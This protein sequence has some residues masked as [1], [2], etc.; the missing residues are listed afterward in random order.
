[1][2]STFAE[3]LTQIEP[4]SAEIDRLDDSMEGRTYFEAEEINK[5]CWELQKKVMSLGEQAITVPTCSA[6]DV[7]DKAA[8]LK[9]YLPHAN[10]GTRGMATCQ[11]LVADI[12]RNVKA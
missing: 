8:I 7:R 12:L 3:I 6:Q 9:A 10:D 11:S 4:L 1:M 5:W 2:A